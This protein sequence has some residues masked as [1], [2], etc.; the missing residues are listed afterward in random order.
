M[1]HC[2]GALRVSRTDSPAI[3]GK[4][5]R[6]DDTAFIPQLSHI[7]AGLQGKIGGFENI[8]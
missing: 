3:I 7:R 4:F 8:F 5:K 1:T 6:F 2:I